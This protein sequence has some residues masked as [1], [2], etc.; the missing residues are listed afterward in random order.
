MKIFVLATVVLAI[1]LPSIANAE[2]GTRGGPGV[3][4]AN[5][6]CKSWDEYSRNP[7][8]TIERRNP[9]VD[10]LPE[11]GPTK[12]MQCSHNLRTDCN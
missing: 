9:N 10:K 7:S 12:T 6:K 8:G 11:W 3:R 1:A 5:G 4:D 2:C